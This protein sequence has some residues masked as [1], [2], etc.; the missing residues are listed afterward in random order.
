MHFVNRT[1]V[2]SKIEPSLQIEHIKVN[3]EAV[4]ITNVSLK[5]DKLTKPRPLMII[6]KMKYKN[7][8]FTKMHYTYS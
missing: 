8:T 1:V 5:Y 6:D 7:L 4:S 3:Q 2:P